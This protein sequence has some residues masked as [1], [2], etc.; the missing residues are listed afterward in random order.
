[1][2]IEEFVLSQIR[3]DAT[4]AIGTSSGVEQPSPQMCAVAAQ[5]SLFVMAK[6]LRG[7]RESR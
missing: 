1:M 7:C 6:H 4:A 3:Y 2:T 5:E